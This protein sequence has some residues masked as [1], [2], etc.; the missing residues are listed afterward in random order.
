MLPRNL[1]R[2]RCAPPRS[3]REPEARAGWAPPGSIEADGD[4][5]NR[6]DLVPKTWL[7]RGPAAD[8]LSKRR[9]SEEL[10]EDLFRPIDYRGHPRPLMRAAPLSAAEELTQYGGRLHHPTPSRHVTAVPSKIENIRITGRNSDTPFAWQLT[11]DEQRA[12]MPQMPEPQGENLPSRRCPGRIPVGSLD[13]V[14]RD[15]LDRAV[16]LWSEEL[17]HLR[18]QKDR[19]APTGLVSPSLRGDTAER[20]ESSRRHEVSHV[21]PFDEKMRPAPSSEGVV[22]TARAIPSWAAY[23][24]AALAGSS[25]ERIISA[26]NPALPCGSPSLTSP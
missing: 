22:V 2:K 26:S 15:S 6:A 23:S 25:A 13:R 24:T 17:P 18:V 10:P 19:S 7:I 4:P 11:E 12:T 20:R 16:H 1:S 3:R 8:E 14:S 5:H 21:T 9:D